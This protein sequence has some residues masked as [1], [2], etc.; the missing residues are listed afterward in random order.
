[1]AV[2][3]GT[4][5]VEM[6]LG[7]GDDADRGIDDLCRAA[8]SPLSSCTNTRARRRP[9]TRWPGAR[10]TPIRGTTSSGS[11]VPR[12][13]PS[14]RNASTQWDRL[15]KGLGG[16]RRR[17]P[18]RPR[19][20]DRGRHLPRDLER[21]DV[22]H[23]AL[24]YNALTLASSRHQG[25][26]AYAREP[27]GSRPSGPRTARGGVGTQVRHPHGDGWAAP[28][29]IDEPM[30]WSAPEA[31]RHARPPSRATSD[32]GTFRDSRAARPAAVGPD[33][34]LAT[35]SRRQVD[36]AGLLALAPGKRVGLGDA[37][38]RPERQ[39][40][41]T[42]RGDLLRGSWRPDAECRRA[43]LLITRYLLGALRHL[44]L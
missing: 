23:V 38:R 36:G 44:M 34:P 20:D 21:Y 1:M 24:P 14:P 33:L 26:A 43:L 6:V 28:A 10:W 22:A 39:L 31:H 2:V 40:A 27:M 29:V 17:R 30:A 9:R 25:C 16:P 41:A 11:S 37:R 42:M 12:T 15:P 32:R 4:V 19:F 7:V 5:H 3:S 35:A 13:S 8:D 18:R